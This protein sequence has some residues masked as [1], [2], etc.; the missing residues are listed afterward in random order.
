MRAVTNTAGK[1][2]PALSD[3]PL[4]R[5]PGVAMSSAVSVESG[6][7]S[8][9]RFR[10]RVLRKT[11]NHVR[12]SLPQLLDLETNFGR[13]V[14][15]AAVGE[16]EA[17]VEVAGFQGG[18]GDFEFLVHSLTTQCRAADGRVAFGIED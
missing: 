2:S 4:A 5:A 9:L 13:Y 16:V 18:D 6:M 12:V 1:A 15:P 14:I 11:L 7:G 10:D 3:S 8:C 17:E